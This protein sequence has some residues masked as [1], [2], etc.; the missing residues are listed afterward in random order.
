MTTRAL[1]NPY[2]AGRSFWAAGAC[3]SCM[4]MIATG[5]PA[6]AQSAEA[7]RSFALNW[8][9]EPGAETCMSSQVLA[10]AIEQLLGPVFERP[11]D[12]ELAIEG[13]IGRDEQQATWRVSIRVSDARGTVLGTRDLASAEPSCHA[14]DAQ[15]VLVIGMAIDPEVALRGL[16]EDLLAQFPGNTDSATQLLAELRAEQAAKAHAA[17]S[18]ATPIEQAAP[19]TQP[20]AEEPAAPETPAPA[21]QPTPAWRFEP[22]AGAA[23]ALGLQ[24]AAVAGVAF[25]MRVRSPSW[26]S[27]VLNGTFWLPAD[28]QLASRQGAVKFYALQGTLA[29]CPRLFETQYWLGSA[30]AGATIGDRWSDA[31]AL[32]VRTSSSRL[33]WAPTGALELTLR[34]AER[35]LVSASPAVGLVLPRDRFKYT[36]ATNDEL[37]LFTPAAVAVWGML[38]VGASY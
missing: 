11:A 15:V 34:P 2:A 30:C 17:Q 37:D 32:A 38:T 10:R 9:R 5:Q 29:F 21:W 27:V 22:L 23:L 6:H 35:W 26:W 24:P 16:P 3:A 4:L 33:Y 28:A 14:L 13:R 20:A 7:P 12:A 36:N 18:D 31:S 8:V 25:G 19:K 1:T